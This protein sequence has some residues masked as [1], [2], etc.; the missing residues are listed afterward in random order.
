MK[1]YSVTD[2]DLI[3]DANLVLSSVLVG[4]IKEGHL[5]Q[6]QGNKIAENYSVIIEDA[7][8]LPK[9]LSEKLE[10]MPDKYGYRLV[11]AVGRFEDK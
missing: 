2:Q 11:R 10:L 1:M 6:E 7:S 3:K 8:W 5:T 9:W 4:L